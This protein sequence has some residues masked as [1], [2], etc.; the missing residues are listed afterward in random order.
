M[1]H[2]LGGQTQLNGRGGNTRHGLLEEAPLNEADMG[3]GLGGEA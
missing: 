1:R 3:H 2:G